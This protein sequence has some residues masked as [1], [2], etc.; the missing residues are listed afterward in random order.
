MDVQTLDPHRQEQA[1]EYSK[2]QRKFMLLDLGL[3]VVLLII[4]LFLGW[5]S[6]LRDWIFSWTENLWI[7]VLAF[8]GI[9]G[10]LFTILDLP[11]SFYT[12]YTL[13]HRYGQSN[14]TI[15]GWW[16]DFAKGLVLSGVIGGIVLEVIYLLLRSAPETWWLWAGGFILLFNVLLAN[17]AP[18]L[19][20]P[21]FYKFTIV[22]SPGYCSYTHASFFCYVIYR[23]SFFIFFHF[24]ILKKLAL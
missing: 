19:L 7:A 22:Q 13:P 8:G 23:I 20:F 24:L 14:Q 16:I 1:K 21:I 18:V 12:G 3:G 2:I 15:K 17:L 9:F 4:W 5:S 6:D 10:L 11:L